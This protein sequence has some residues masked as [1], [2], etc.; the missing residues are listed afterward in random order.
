MNCLQNRIGIK[1]CGTTEPAGGYVHTMPGLSS[2]S[3]EKIANS[4]QVTGLEVLSAVEG[5]AIKTF[6]TSLTS[7]LASKFKLKRLQE[8]VDLKKLI[9]T[10]TTTSGANEWRGF[11]LDTVPERS[12]DGYVRSPL[13]CFHI[14]SF[15]LYSPAVE[16]NVEVAV[17]DLQTGTKVFTS[18]QNL[19]I[20]WNLITVNEYFSYPRIFCA[21]DSNSINSV[22]QELIENCCACIDNCCGTIKGAK[23][24]KTSTVTDV[25]E[26]EDIYG[27]SAIYSLQCKFDALVCNNLDL[28]GDAYAQC[29]ASSYC[30]YALHTKRHNE[31][32]LNKDEINELKDYYDLEFQK[33]LQ[34]AVD[35]IE[36]D[37]DCCIECS[38]PITQ[39][40]NTL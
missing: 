35:G 39:V 15:N 19:V 13:H 28:F 18:T 27:L 10:T 11:V 8:S 23:S 37:Q 4:E 30:L 29:F 25:T 17:F 24:T 40:W 34:E 32:T 16:S 1:G 3:F 14:Q 5:T 6:R 22:T 21:Y 2:A 31:H 9:D 20:G 38:A 7:K 26:G 33:K 12:E 36:L